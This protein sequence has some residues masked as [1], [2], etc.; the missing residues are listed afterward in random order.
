MSDDD[1]FRA[2]QRGKVDTTLQLLQQLLQQNAPPSVFASAL[3]VA[4]WNDHGDI[5]REIARLVGHM[6]ATH[7]WEFAAHHDSPEATRALMQFKPSAPE[8]HSALQC[9]AFV[10]NA[11]TMALLIPFVPSSS[12]R[13]RALFTAALIGHKRAVRTLIRARVDVNTG[14]VSRTALHGAAD[15]GHSQ[16]VKQLLWYKA[17]IRA[18]T[19]DGKTALDLAIQRQYVATAA[20]LR[21]FAAKVDSMRDFR[22]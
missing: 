6:R 9:A 12:H 19:H 21:R 22:K 8:H 14:L 5:V 18:F 15:C 10:G 1:L 13:Q 7:Y 4:I 17:D 3:K 16:V 20:V 11:A 2:A